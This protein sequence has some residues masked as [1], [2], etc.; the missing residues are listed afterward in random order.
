MSLLARRL[1]LSDIP[2]DEIGSELAAKQSGKELEALTVSVELGNVKRVLVPIAKCALKS[3]CVFSDR[4]Q[5]E[6]IIVV[7]DS[8]GKKKEKGE[9]GEEEREKKEGEQANE[10]EPDTE[11]QHVKKESVSVNMMMMNC[12]SGGFH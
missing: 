10:K 8:K 12:A 2:H 7:E 3:V 1:S 4:A 5:V 6:R 11:D 9:E